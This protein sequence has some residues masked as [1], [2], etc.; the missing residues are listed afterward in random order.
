MKGEEKRGKTTDTIAL[1]NVM[2]DSGLSM[3]AW[4]PVQEAARSHIFRLYIY[5]SFIYM[6]LLDAHNFTPPHAE[7]QTLFPGK[8]EQRVFG[9]AD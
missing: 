6:K 8:L 4:T 5:I 1:S 7:D 3:G 9:N 2:R